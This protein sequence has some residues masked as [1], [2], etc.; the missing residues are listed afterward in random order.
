MSERI[1][2]QIYL[3]VYG[4]DQR[5]MDDT[6]ES[7][8]ITWCKDQIHDTDELYVRHTHLGR[9]LRAKDD[10]DQDIKALR[11]GL[12]FQV[13]RTCDAGELNDVLREE[14]DAALASLAAADEEL[15]EQAKT[16]VRLRMLTGLIIAEFV[17]IKHKALAHIKF[18]KLEEDT[19]EATN[20]K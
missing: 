18:A 17:P 20:G 4:A 11:K 15:A 7:P 3:Q 2:D 12:E 9:A 13:E 10:Y 5:D 8:E 1:P 16:I 6:Q 19:R 14:R